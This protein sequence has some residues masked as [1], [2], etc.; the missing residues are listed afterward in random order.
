MGAGVS[1]LKERNIGTKIAEEE[2][3]TDSDDVRVCQVLQRDTISIQRRTIHAQ[4]SAVLL[5]A[6]AHDSYRKVRTC[7]SHMQ[8][9]HSSILQ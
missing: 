3:C 7:Q 9:L 2:H 5:R 1:I 4:P 6:P 8:Q